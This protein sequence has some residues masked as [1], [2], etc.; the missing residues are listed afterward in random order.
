MKVGNGIIYAEYKNKQYDVNVEIKAIKGKDAKN[1]DQSV[2]FTIHR[3][4]EEP[5]YYLYLLETDEWANNQ[6]PSFS[7]VGTMAGIKHNLVWLY[8]TDMMNDNDCIDMLTACGVLFE[9]PAAPGSGAYEDILEPYGNEETIYGI[10]RY[11]NI[12]YG[13]TRYDDRA[14]HEDY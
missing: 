3:H 7:V 9:E 2:L 12:I 1:S 8:A 11:D 14:D 5:L 10:T 4:L 13:V 6:A